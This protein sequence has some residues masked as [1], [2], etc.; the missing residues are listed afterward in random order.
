MMLLGKY[1]IQE[2]IGRGGFGTVYKAHDK[3]LDRTVAIKVLHPNLVNDSTFLARFQQEAKIT[4]RLDHPNLVPVYD[5]GET[6]GRYYIVMAY[7]PGGSVKDLINKYTKLS[8]EQS[9]EIFEDFGRGLDYAHKQSI[10]H[11]DLKPANIL[12]DSHGKARISDMGFAKMIQSN[13]STSITAS[14]GIVG[15]P[16]YMAPEIWKGKASTPAVDIYSSAC[17]LVEM[18]TGKQLFEGD[19]TPMVMMKHFEKLQLPEELPQTWKPVFEKALD[20][21]ANQRF[22]SLESMLTAL[23]SDS[24]QP[25]GKVPSQ[26]KSQQPNFED[27]AAS[28]KTKQVQDRTSNGTFHYGGWEKEQANARQFPP[29]SEQPKK[30]NILYIALGTI[31]VLLVIVIYLLSGSFQ[32]SRTVNNRD[33]PRVEQEVYYVSPTNRPTAEPEN[34]TVVSEQSEPENMSLVSEQ[35]EPTETA[36]AIPA[37][38]NS[39]YTMFTI[40]QCGE[41]IGNQVLRDNCFSQIQNTRNLGFRAN[42]KS[43]VLEP[44]NFEMEMDGKILTCVRSW[45]QADSYVCSGDH[46]R[47]DSNLNI[48]VFDRQSNHELGM[49]V[50]KLFMPTSAPTAAPA[51]APTNPPPQPTSRYGG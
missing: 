33:E 46:Q 23:K 7:M 43:T 9:I 22:D 47:F 21:E 45:S 19:S 1:E 2:E 31:A 18:L 40:G 8:K 30:N 42:F 32:L 26:Q 49:G 10:I 34:T 28:Q 13:S 20:K 3:V 37:I 38:S 41:Q 48:R 12:I 51:P 5:F 44:D 29:Q 50:L 16:A 27:Q 39:S 24:F 11:R 36:T 6:E 25:S 4:A 15:T 17:I 14:G 35:A